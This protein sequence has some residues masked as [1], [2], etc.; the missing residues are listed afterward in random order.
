MHMRY[1]LAVMVLLALAQRGWRAI[2]SSSAVVGSNA[3]R[4]ASCLLVLPLIALGACQVAPRA[5]G[6]D[7]SSTVGAAVQATVQAQQVDRTPAP[8]NTNGGSSTTTT[9]TP[10]PTVAVDEAFTSAPEGWPNTTQGP[11][12]YANGIYQ[13]TPKVSGQFVAINA[14]L[15]GPVRDVSVSG[16]FHKA[17]GPAGGGYGLIVNDQHPDLR[18]GVNQGGRF[19]VLE[20]GD[21]G[22]VGVWQREQ[23]RWVDLLVWTA[24]PAV[25][26]G[27]ASNDLT[28]R[29]HGKQLTFVVNGAQVAQVTTELAD[30]RVGVFVG[31]DGNQIVLERFAVQSPASGIA[32]A[33]WPP[34]PTPTPSSTELLARLDT[35]WS[36]GD[37]PQAFTLLDQLERVD[38]SALDFQDKRYAAHMA[39]GQR[40]LALG[41]KDGAIR[42]FSI[43]DG[44]DSNRGDAKAALRALMPSLTPTPA[45]SITGQ[46]DP[47]W[48]DRAVALIRGYD[49]RYGTVLATALG[50]TR[51]VV[52]HERG[53]WA[54]FVPRL[55]TITLDPVLETEEPEAVATVLAHEAQHAADMYLNGFLPTEA[56]C[57]S[58]EISAFHIQA[59]MW[60]SLQGTAGTTNPRTKLERELNQILALA[61][62]DPARLLSDIRGGYEDQCSLT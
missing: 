53:A 47:L 8:K 15:A 52:L 56:A 61:R 13:L 25:H 44:I 9:G 38:P 2:R 22:T 21:E 32:G 48:L 31:G 19:V 39:A 20:V 45:P 57:Y 12:R 10:A 46:A 59:A 24:N 50:R 34:Q 33:S 43:A 28:V 42:E 5:T 17:G 54:A 36:R 41:N 58:Y 29:A 62:R 7:V 27:T 26:T 3:R 6:P 16:R 30:G 40:W 60:Q 18:D 51:I 35:V 49:R 1:L 55:R 14:P 37:W 11:A 4:H 23:D